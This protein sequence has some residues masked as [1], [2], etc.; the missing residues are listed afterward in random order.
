MQY[1]IS[2][3]LF[4]AAGIWLDGRFPGLKPL[5]TLLGFGIGFV[6][7]TASLIYQVLGTEREKKQ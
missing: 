4:T 3:A 2:I 7:G 1:G 6:G 5:F